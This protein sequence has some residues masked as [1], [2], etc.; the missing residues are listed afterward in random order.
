MMSLKNMVRGLENH[1][2]ANELIKLWEHDAGTLKYWR[3]SSNFVYLFHINGKPHYL[4]F[5][6][7]EDNSIGNIRAELDFMLYLLDQGFATVAP[8]RSKNGNEI[9]SISTETGRYYGV[10]FKQAKGQ[11]LSTDQMSEQHLEAW[12]QSLAALHCLSDSYDHESTSQRSWRDAL[13]FI[14]AVL[15]RYPQ[16]YGARQELERVQNLLSALPTGNGHTGLIHYDFETDNVFYL[17]E[18]LRYCAIDFDDAMVHWF[19]M[20]I[21]SAISDLIDQDD[22]EA[23]QK[24]QSFL[25]GYR[26]LKPIDKCYM[27]LMPIFQRFAD[28]Y[29]F[30]RLLRSV[31]NMDNSC[32]PDWAI[33]L[34]DKLLSVCDRI[35]AGYHPIIEL[36]SVNQDNWYACTQLEISNEQQSVFPVPAVYWLAESAYCGF[37]PLAIFAEGELAGLSVFAVDPIDGSCWIMAFMID[38]KH[39]NKGIGRAGMEE[40]LRYIRKEHGFDQII[41]GHRPENERASH[42]YASLGFTE[43]NRNEREVIL[44][45][46]F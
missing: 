31:E 46:T 42:L 23:R 21:T 15:Q 39:Q 28:L 8:V 7:E 41:L 4:R 35:R 36:R 16:E 44:Q 29:T 43:I 33:T 45:Y 17:A 27:D 37:T 34:K 10:V 24:I 14:R 6:H 26:S 40:L 11:Y 2:P 3:A 5:I 22:E 1:F 9:E 20:D 38:R 12:G 25:A 13:A 19:A 18:E 32:S 30:A